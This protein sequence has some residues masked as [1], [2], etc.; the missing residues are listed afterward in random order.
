VLAALECARGASDLVCANVAPESC[1]RKFRD[2]T[3]CAA[4]QRPATQA[5]ASTSL[6]EG[7]AMYRDEQYGI[8]APLPEQRDPQHS[9]SDVLVSALHPDGARYTIRKLARPDAP[10]LNQKIFLKVA[11]NLLGRCSDK[12][13][14]QGL[15]EKAGRASMHYTTTCPDGSEERGLFWGTD[16]ALFVASVRGPAGRLGP[17]DT[18]LYGFEVK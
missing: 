5:A 17:T 18:F 15:V 14:L 13:K 12:M 1:A 6:P 7:F 10:Q 3:V 8:S 11:M 2:V 16:T 4:G 9:E